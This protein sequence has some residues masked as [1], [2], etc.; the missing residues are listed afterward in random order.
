[1]SMWDPTGLGTEASFDMF[2]IA[3][4]NLSLNSKEKQKWQNAYDTSALVQWTLFCV[5][6]LSVEVAVE[7]EQ[8]VQH[9]D[10]SKEDANASPDDRGQD[11]KIVEGSSDNDTGD[12]N[13]TTEEQDLGKRRKNWIPDQGEPNTTE[14]NKPGTTT[15]KYGPDGWVQ[16]EFHKGHSGKSIPDVEK[17]DH[18]HD[19]KPNPYHPIK[20]PERMPG[21]PPKKKELPEYKDMQ[22]GS[23]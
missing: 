3:K 13:S 2:T 10:D 18:V 21:R 20:R 11:E 22:K 6:Y 1:M 4:S 17:K 19:H 15:K 9:L 14:T 8:T 7:I 5:A 12:D 23:K 16:K